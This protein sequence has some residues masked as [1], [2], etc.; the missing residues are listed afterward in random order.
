MRSIGTPGGHAF[1][2]GAIRA[3]LPLGC[4]LVILGFCIGMVVPA[5]AGALASYAVLC[6]ATVAV[7]GAAV[8]FAQRIDAFFKGA[9]GE[10]DI[11]MA[12]AALPD[13]FTVVH[14]VHVRTE[15]GPVEIDHLVVS[16]G[17]IVSVETKNWHGT[18]SV[19]DG[20]LLINGGEPSRDPVE[21]ARREASALQE[22]LA[23]NVHAAPSVTPVLCFNESTIADG[24]PHVFSAVVLCRRDALAAT[25]AAISEKESIS[26]ETVN[27]VT[28]ALAGVK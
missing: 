18:V 14:D 20:R 21:Q 15:S 27:L 26:A 4:A 16:R 25:I 10:R 2:R 23:G 7:L 5:T 1:M 9:C 8:F 17:G 3:A 19:A 24:T 11:A 6:A 28:N 13:S 12:L 22:W